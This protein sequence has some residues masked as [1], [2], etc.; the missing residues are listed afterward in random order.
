[1][2]LIHEIELSGVVRSDSIPFVGAADCVVVVVVG[3]GV[4]VL[5]FEEVQG[6]PHPCQLWPFVAPW[7]G[8]SMGS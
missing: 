6:H 8:A 1:M 7:C 5:I 3:G 2:D 4:G